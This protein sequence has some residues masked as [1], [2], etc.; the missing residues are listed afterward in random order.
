MFYHGTLFAQL[1]WP[2]CHCPPQETM[3]MQVLNLQKQQLLKQEQELKA[4]EAQLEQQLALDSL[5]WQALLKDKDILL[6]QWKEHN[7]ALR[8]QGASVGGS[9]LQIAPCLLMGFGVGGKGY[10]PPGQ[11]LPEA[12]SMGSG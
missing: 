7:L 12:R 4:K 6:E 5:K 9:K 8:Q 3:D 2:L 11:A 10:W 1:T